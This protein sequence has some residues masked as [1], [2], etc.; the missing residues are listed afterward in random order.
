[1][2]SDADLE[3]LS[4][5]CGVDLLQLKDK[6]SGVS[7]AN[8]E[9]PE[10]GKMS[11]EEARVTQARLDQYAVC[12]SC[13][14]SGLMRVVYNFVSTERNCSECGGDGLLTKLAERVAAVQSEL[15]NL[16]HESPAPAPAP[17][18]E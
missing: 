2:A 6:Y 3:R 13:Q 12:Q 11:A 5:A 16:E 17:V 10:K 8:K 4:A 9:M 15:S 14:G 1:M 7:K 18:P